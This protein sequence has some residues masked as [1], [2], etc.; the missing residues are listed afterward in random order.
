LTYPSGIA[1]TSSGELI[2]ADTGNHAIRLL[3]LSGDLVTIAGQAGRQ[4]YA[5]GPAGS[6]LFNGPV[7]IRVVGDDIYVADTSN[8]VIRKISIDSSLRRRAVHH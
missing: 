7:G 6:A 8:F 5:D 3:T 4:G 2:I 1:L